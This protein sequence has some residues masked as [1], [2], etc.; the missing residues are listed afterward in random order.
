MAKKGTICSR[1]KYVGL[2]DNAATTMR[3]WIKDNEYESDIPT[4]LNILW[5]KVNDSS[6]GKWQFEGVDGEMSVGDI[7]KS[8]AKVI[9][10]HRTFVNAFGDQALLGKINTQLKQFDPSGWVS[11]QEQIIDEIERNEDVEGS[12]VDPA[13][14]RFEETGVSEIDISS[15]DN[16]FFQAVNKQI[17]P[18][19]MVD[20]EQFAENLSMD[21]FEEM[22]IRQF[23][24]EEKI[25][26][27]GRK[28]ITGYK[29]TPYA[30]RDLVRFYN[31]KQAINKVKLKGQG[32]ERVYIAKLNL[33][34]NIAKKAKNVDDLAD[35]ITTNHIW[36]PEP[37]INVK[38]KT[39]SSTTGTA[40]C[41]L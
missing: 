33:D 14:T 29:K 41:M 8:A 4:A 40:S 22:V 2:I 26:A 11:N 38:T 10:P 35:A 16:I 5:N 13:N 28:F 19:M 31:A 1:A 7:F 32:V 27:Q 21:E 36:Q 12:P 34:P 6:K 3:E 24:L 25:D 17:S 30:R 37:P 18:S 20:I 9:Y 39:I 15:F 23:P